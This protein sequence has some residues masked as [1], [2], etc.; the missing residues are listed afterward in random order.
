MMKG[1]TLLL[2]GAMTLPGM[3]NSTN[4][5]KNGTQWTVRVGSSP[6][7]MKTIVY[8]LD[9]EG[10][11]EVEDPQALRLV[12]TTEEGEQAL[13]AVILSEGDKVYFWDYTDGWRLLYDFSLEPGDE[14]VLYSGMY[15]PDSQD[16]PESVVAKCEKV[17]N[18]LGNIPF[19]AGVIFL[20]TSL[21]QTETNYSQAVW[22]NGLGS[23]Q[24]PLAN[25]ENDIDGITMN[26]VK[27]TAG[28]EVIFDYE[29]LVGI[30]PIVDSK[31]SSSPVYRLDGSPDKGSRV[32]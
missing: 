30:A 25:F 28:E 23:I 3:A 8:L 14:T 5:F 4:Y 19:E 22:Y 12:S 18:E 11:P 26:L 15:R 24:G 27:V 1:K 9:D 31:D 17:V 29:S 2:I 6:S 21:A 10:V 32:S 13:G 7:Y 20:T 16:Y